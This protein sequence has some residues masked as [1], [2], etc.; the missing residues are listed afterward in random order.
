[1]QRAAELTDL[2]NALLLEVQFRLWCE[3]TC[4]YDTRANRRFY[5]KRL[6]SLLSKLEG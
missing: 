1:M 5:A 3:R 6:P 2:A 4:S